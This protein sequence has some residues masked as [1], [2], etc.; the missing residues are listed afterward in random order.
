MYIKSMSIKNMSLVIVGALIL[1]VISG[2]LARSIFVGIALPILLV[3]FFVMWRYMK[4][5]PE[6]PK[7]TKEENNV[8]PVTSDNI[9]Q[10]KTEEP[11]YYQPPKERV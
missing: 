9:P 6:K 10:Q 8:S 3:I 1:G 11:T 7:I 2:F 4:N 5:N